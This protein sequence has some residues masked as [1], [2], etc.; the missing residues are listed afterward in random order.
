MTIPVLVSQFHPTKR[1]YGELEG[2]YDVSGFGASA[3]DT[4]SVGGKTFVM[5]QNCHRNT[6]HEHWA[7]SLD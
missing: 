6:P 4:I 7:L 5:F 3:E 1:I 2:T